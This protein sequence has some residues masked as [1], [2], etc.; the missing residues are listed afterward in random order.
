MRKPLFLFIPLLLF[1]SKVSAQALAQDDHKFRFAVMGC[2]H[3]GLTG[4]RDWEP[5]VSKIK[6]YEPD[7]VL[8]LGGMV[9]VSGDKP[10]EALWEEFDGVTK[11]L[12]VPVYDIP[13]DTGTSCDMA[14]V[15]ADERK[16]AILDKLFQE[17]YKGRYYSFEHKDNL[18]ICLDS[19][20]EA[21][22]EMLDFLKKAISESGN[23]DNVFIAIHRPPPF[24]GESIWFKS[25]HPLIKEKVKFVFSAHEHILVKTELDGVNY[26]TT[27]CPPL[28][29]KY[30]ARPYFFHFLIVDVDKNDVSVKIVPLGPIPLEEMA[31]YETNTRELISFFKAKFL[32]SQLEVQALTAPERE[33]ILQPANVIRALNIKPGM[34]ILDVGAGAGFFTFQ[35][36]EALKG[37]G[38]VVASEVDPQMV[39]LIKMKTRE[40]KY[41]N[42]FPLLVSP[43]GL[44][45]LLKQQSYDI[46]FLSEV[47]HY[48]RDP[49]DYFRRLRSLLKKTGR[50]YI[51]HFK[52]VSEFSDIEFDFKR[53]AQILSSE[54]DD[55]PIFQRMSEKVQDF[56]KGWQGGDIPQEIQKEVVR[57]FNRMLSER[58]LFNDL[59]SYYNPQDIREFEWG[60]PLSAM[61]YARDLRLAK[62]LA[63]QLDAQGTF[64]S[65]EGSLS[66]TEEGRLRQLNRILLTGIFRTTKLQRLKGES[67]IYVE[68]DSII[69]D[70]E[71]AGFSFVKGYDFLPHHYFLEFRRRH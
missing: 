1:L 34:V 7:F 50:L 12:G 40:G 28:L 8:F 24:R 49:G 69:S 41:G 64:G 20:R 35:L 60:K 39:E 54:G 52:N 63:V 26:I 59:M 43:Q 4:P 13:S 37:T 44:D 48:L 16:K 22:Q 25:V 15:A 3:F 21:Q 61:C 55:F 18:F 70:L 31:A 45:P 47:Y 51:I 67:P 9:D 17:R 6:E 62:W 5:A 14:P 68:R 38:K 42:V 10:A 46:I 58:L 23:Y 53:V 2:M 30:P 56:I 57:D 27:G 36:A 71:E 11:A 66:E 32:P 65:R 29:S 19:E 33:A